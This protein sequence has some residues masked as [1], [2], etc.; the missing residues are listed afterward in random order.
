VNDPCTSLF[1]VETRHTPNPKQDGVSTATSFG[2]IFPSRSLGPKAP[3]AFTPS[4]IR[5]RAQAAAAPWLLTKDDVL[6]RALNIAVAFIGIVVTAPAMLLIALLV[7]LTSEGPALFRQPRVGVDRRLSS[8]PA[9]Q[10]Q[11]RTADMGGRVFTMYKFRTMR[12]QQS[13][14]PQV[15]ASPRD[16]RITSVG[17]FLRATRLDELPQLFN[18]LVGDMNI[19]GPRPEQPEIFQGLRKE[20]TKY[21]HRQRVLPGITGLAQVSLPYDQTVDDVRR[22]VNLDLE[23]IRQRSAAQD[24]VIM[25]KTMPVMV[26]GKGPK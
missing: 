18:V 14:A 12:V 2:R 8:G 16:P 26:F 25:A 5:S 11:R 1:R 7:K 15:W 22:K 24:L 13:S 20:I 23:Y 3:P 17:R 10:G 4:G 6:C 21:R 9:A 19:V